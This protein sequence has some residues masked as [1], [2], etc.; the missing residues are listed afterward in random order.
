MYVRLWG[1]PFNGGGIWFSRHNLRRCEIC[2]RRPHL[3]FAV[4]GLSGS[5]LI[6]WWP[7]QRRPRG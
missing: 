6:Q 4:F 3:W 1:A 7:W 5:F 2:W